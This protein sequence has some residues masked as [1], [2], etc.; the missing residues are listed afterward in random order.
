LTLSFQAWPAGQVAS[1]TYTLTLVAPKVPVKTE[2]VS[3]RLVRTLVHPDRRAS[4]ALLRF[5]ADGRRLAVAGYPSGVLQIWD[6]AVGRELSR[7]ETPA[8]YRGTDDYIALTANWKTAFTPHDGRKVTWIEVNGERRAKVEYDGDV[9]V[10]DVAT[11]KPRPAVKLGPDRGASQ[12]I[13]SPDGTKL[14]TMEAR[15]HDP[16]ETR[17]MIPHAA[18]FRD[19]SGEGQPVELATGFAMAAFAPDGKTFVLT[20]GDREKGESRLRLFDGSTGKEM[21][22]LADEPKAN[23]FYPTYSPHGAQVAAEVRELGDKT[24]VFKVWDPASRREVA[25]L[26]PAEPGLLFQPVFSTDGRLVFGCGSGRGHIWDATTG[27]LL[28]TFRF[29]EKGYVGAVAVSPDGRWAAAVG[30][31]G[32]SIDDLRRDRE[33]GHDLQPHAVLYELTTGKPVEA[34]ICPTGLAN[35]AAFSPDGKTL[36]VGGHGAVHLF[37]IT[38][39]SRQRR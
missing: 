33:L 36:A 28:S 35:R 11:G 4:I 17:Y 10:W 13:V 16:K 9:R 6:A 34:I 38:D 8:G 7:A 3:S 27:A 5:S 18:V 39:L 2:R 25:V 15:S 23:I 19:L 37:D 31:P 30:V 22:V 1:T 26:K 20:T 14:I 29:G 21:A 24:S 32:V 12:A